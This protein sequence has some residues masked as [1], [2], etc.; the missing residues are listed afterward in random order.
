MFVA[1]ADLSCAAYDCLS[2]DVAWMRYK[3]GTEVEGALCSPSLALC[4]L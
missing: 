1:C 4:G 3:G 2:S